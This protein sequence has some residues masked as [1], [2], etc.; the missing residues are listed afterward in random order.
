MDD[1]KTQATYRIDP[2]PSRFTVQVTAGGMLS[3]FGHNPV[4]AI[5]D[6]SGEARIQGDNLEAASL[7]VEVQASSLEVAD[8][9][10]DKDRREIERIMQ[11]KV[12][13]SADNPVITFDS[14]SVQA[15]SAGP[16]QYR[17]Q[18]SGKL[19]LNGTSSDQTI[20]ARVIVSADR[21]RASGEFTLLQS[22]YGIEQV[23]VAGGVLKVKD[24][25][26]V[27]F[28]IVASAVKAAGSVA[29]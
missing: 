14:S 7:H 1:V 10:S 4:I 13:R 26:K 9:V 29:A 27:S 21:L 23:V 24:E 5:R 3:A 17:V 28:D 25:L 2:R 6:F 15:T 8:D 12:L 18:I 22:T 11:E 19:T 16:G 20:T